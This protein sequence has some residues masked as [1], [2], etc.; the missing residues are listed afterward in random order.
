VEEWELLVRRDDLAAAE[1][2]PLSPVPLRAGDVRLAPEVFGLTSNNVTYARLGESEMPFLEAFP[3]PEGFGNVPVWGFARVVESRYPGIDVGERFFGY[4]P[5]ATQHVVPAAANRRGFVDVSS[6][7]E[8]LHTWYRTYVRAG[9]PDPDDGRTSVLRP[10]YPAS[11]NLAEFAV[12]QIGGGVRSVLVT[13]ASSKTALGFAARLSRMATVPVIGVTSAT[14]LEFTRAR[15]CYGTVVSYD[16]LASAPVSGPALFV[17]F[18]GEAKRLTAVYQ[19]FAE[20]LRHTALVGYTHPGAEIDPPPLPPPG[21][22]VFFTP[23]VEQEAIDRDGEADYFRRY[24]AA[25]R[26]FIAG[27]KSWLEL[28]HGH[29]PDAVADAFRRLLTAAPP[30][31]TAIV[32]SPR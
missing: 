31:T 9:E 26:R 24:E 21:P 23:A 20:D 11:Y 27:T 7:R 17:D 16:D 19:Q 28:E 5:M 14:S 30:P 10:L 22:K 4:L 18:T 12:R 3:A 8:F 2:R 25:E 6:T 1:L 13:S 29:G 15:G 32:L